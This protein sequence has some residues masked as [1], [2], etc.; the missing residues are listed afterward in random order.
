MIIREEWDKFRFDGP[1]PFKAAWYRPIGINELPSPA[2]TLYDV[3]TFS[4]ECDESAFD[5]DVYLKIWDVPFRWYCQ[6][7][8]AACGNKD[9]I[10]KTKW[11]RRE[12]L[13]GKGNRN[14][15]GFSEP[16]QA[17]FLEMNEHAKQHSIM[18]S[19]AKGLK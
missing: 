19:W 8:F 9:R 17:Q 11:E 16:T 6:D 4:P 3:I 12:D 14:F 13:G 7:C 10:F 1:R 15:G 18:W 2:D 5:P